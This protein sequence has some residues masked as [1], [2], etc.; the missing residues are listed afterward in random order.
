MSCTSQFQAS[1][2]I[3]TSRN[4]VLEGFTSSLWGLWTHRVED[5]IVDQGERERQDDPEQEHHHAGYG[6][7][8]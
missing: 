1:T 2:T 8:A 4:K 7:T 6:Q 5:G 3:P